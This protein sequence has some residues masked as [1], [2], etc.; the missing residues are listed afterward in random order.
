MLVKK[1]QGQR[2]CFS[3]KKMYVSPCVKCV[4]RV[5][6]LF[7]KVHIKCIKSMFVLWGS[8]PWTIF[9]LS[10]TNIHAS[11]KMAHLATVV[12]CSRS[13]HF[14]NWRR[15]CTWV[16][17]YVLAETLRRMFFQVKYTHGRPKIVFVVHL[18]LHWRCIVR[19]W[20]IKIGWL[21][22]EANSLMCEN[23]L[24]NWF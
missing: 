2:E 16:S 4:V 5:H 23:M 7:K 8:R 11:V 9:Q 13:N 18:H 1:S 14:V 19:D 12:M 22:M 21:Q 10:R 6:L 17:H 15:N 3:L 24:L 20:M